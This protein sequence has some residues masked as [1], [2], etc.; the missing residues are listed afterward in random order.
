MKTLK[1]I[2]VCLLA[3]I[4]SAHADKGK[5]QGLGNLLEAK[6]KLNPK[7]KFISLYA[8]AGESKFVSVKGEVGIPKYVILTR[9]FFKKKTAVAVLSYDNQTQCTFD[10]KKAF[11]PFVKYYFKDCN[12]GA[13][14]GDHIRVNNGVSL[15][16]EGSSGVTLK[17][18]VLVY[19]YIQKGIKLPDMDAKEGQVLVFDGEIWSPADY[20][21]DG[22]AQG[23]ALLW[24]GSSWV[25]SELPSIQG[26]QG[27][28]GLPG[29]AGPQGPQ[30]EQGPAGPQGEKGEKGDQG[31][32]GIAGAQGAKGDKGD[33]GIAGPQGPAGPQGEKGD[34]GIPGVAGAAGPQGPQGPAGAQGPQ[35]LPGAQGPQGPAGPQGEQG[36]PGVAGPVGPQGPQGVAG[37]QGPVGPQGEQGPKGEDGKDAT[38]S[39]TAGAGIVAGTDAGGKIGSTG[40]IAVN[41]GTAA[42]QIPQLDSQGK[43]PA[44]VM[45]AD[46]GSGSSMEVAYLKDIK[47]SGTH[48]GDCTA[49]VWHQRTLNNLQGGADFVSLAGNQF[50][51]QPGTYNFQVIAPTYLDN[52]HK[53]IL[54]NVSGNA[55]ALVGSTGRT[56]VNYGGMNSSF[57][58]GSVEVTAPTIFEVRHRC[59]S[60]RTIVGFGLAAN[61]GVDEVYTQI[62]IVKTK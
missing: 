7:Q 45:P 50:T 57:I 13:V 26:P 58:N 55:T 6:S 15:H 48:G 19:K 53:A 34:Q 59:S 12:D 4:L 16:V 31:P 33:Q 27:E 56:H 24:D 25:P 41:V 2:C 42:G 3:G 17:A 49:G 28:Q 8:S 21:P 20:L 60:D 10:N 37:P 9:G 18:S 14:P 51:L 43:L 47:P 5:S 35:G 40:T 62:T 22:Q 39:L 1:V 38:V 54:F 30:G 23:Q 61:F 32:Q 46:S 36:I 29:V 11:G 52:I 44:S